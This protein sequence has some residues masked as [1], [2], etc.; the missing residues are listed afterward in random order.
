MSGIYSF[1]M[2]SQNTQAKKPRVPRN[3]NAIAV[4]SIA[5]S[6]IMLAAPRQHCRPDEGEYHKR[7][8]QALYLCPP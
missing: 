4:A 8:R 3:T 1:L 2:P 5:S 6:Y 7:Q